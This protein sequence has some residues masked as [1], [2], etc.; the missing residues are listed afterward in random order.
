MAKV[1][2]VDPEIFTKW[3]PAFADMTPDQIASAYAGAGSYIATIEGAIGLDIPT[4]TR[5]VYLA[6]AHNLY[7]QSHPDAARGQVTSA[8]EMDASASFNVPQTKNMMEYWLSLSPY[9]L[10]LLAIL[11]TVQPPLPRTPLNIWPYYGG[12]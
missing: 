6:T 4:Q 10:E 2:N 3:F 5:G 9:G 12:I 7:M 8:S 1:I 11:A